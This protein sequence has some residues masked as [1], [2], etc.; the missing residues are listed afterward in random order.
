M[1]DAQVKATIDAMSRADLWAEMVKGSRSTFQGDRRDYLMARFHLLDEAEHD[2]KVRRG[3]ELAAEAGR[4]AKAS[5]SAAEEA[6]RIA[7]VSNR[8][9]GI[10]LVVSVLAVLIAIAAVFLP[11]HGSDRE[12]AVEAGK[13]Q[14][15]R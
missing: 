15:V 6:N 4:I 13:V 8:R 10:A 3:A 5:S 11:H 7:R 2:E 9:A 1:L 12:H 14:K